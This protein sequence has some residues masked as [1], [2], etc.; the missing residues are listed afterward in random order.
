M[1]LYCTASRP[2]VG[3]TQP[4]IQWEPRALSQEVK[5]PGLKADRSPPPSAEVKSDGD[6]LNYLSTGT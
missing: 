5:L 4:P 3:S 1:F 6:I 2:A